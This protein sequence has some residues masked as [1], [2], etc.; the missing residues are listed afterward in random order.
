MATVMLA[1]PAESRSAQQAQVLTILTAPELIRGDNTEVYADQTTSSR[2]WLKGIRAA[3]EILTCPHE[4]M[5]LWGLSLWWGRG[6]S[7][8]PT[9]RRAIHWGAEN[10]VPSRVPLTGD[11]TFPS[12]PW[13]CMSSGSWLLHTTLPALSSLSLCHSFS[14]HGKPLWRQAELL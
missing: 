3:G 4:S 6:L 5:C 10:A 11:M 9:K 8:D 12:F 2:L 1:F 7:E 13:P 14:L